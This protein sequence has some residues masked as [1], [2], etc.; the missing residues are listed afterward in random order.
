MK[1]L[2]VS[3]F[4]LTTFAFATTINVPADYPTI[5]AG[6]DAA[7]DGDTVSVASGNYVENVRIEKFI[8]LI[9]QNKETTIIDGNQNGAVLLVDGNQSDIVNIS[10]FTLTNGQSLPWGGDFGTVGSGLVAHQTNVVAE[11]LIIHNNFSGCCGAAIYFDNADGEINNVQIKD[12]NGSNMVVELYASSVEASNLLIIQN[13]AYTTVI[14][15]YNGTLNLA[16]STVAH[17]T[18]E[19]AL[20]NSNNVVISNSIFIN[21]TINEIESGATVSYSNINGGWEGEENIDSDPQFTDPD[22]GD[23]TLQGDS[24]CIDAGNPEQIDPDGSIRDIGANFI[25]NLEGDCNLD[26]EQNVIDVIYN[27]NNC[28]LEE[29]PIIQ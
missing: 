14:N 10:S 22:I 27:L 28:I 18:G 25:P 2:V 13:D 29:L 8:H 15:C 26:Y 19:Y 6:I 20:R 4:V 12:N 5:Q 1:R 7:S 21:E 16:S 23:F 24:P 9:G 3:L 11:D 17:N